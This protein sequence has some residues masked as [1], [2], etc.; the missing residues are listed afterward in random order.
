MISR[1][2]CLFSILAFLWFGCKQEKIIPI[3]TV[4]ALDDRLTQLYQQSDFPGFSVAVVSQDQ[5]VYQKGFGY[6]DLAQKTPFTTQ[7]IQ[8]IGSVSKTFIAAALMKAVEEGHFTLET[9]INDIL[10]F[11]VVN[12]YFPDSPIQVKHLVTHTSGITDREAAY[13][14]TYVFEEIP[15]VTLK[16]FLF[17]YF[18][19]KGRLYSQDNFINRAP[20]TTYRYTNLG[21]ALAAY[22]IEVK[23]GMSFAEYCEKAI[24][25]PLQ[26]TDSHWFYNSTLVPAYATLYKVNREAYPPYSL[27]TYP[28]GGL[29]TSCQDLSRYMVEMLKGCAGK[30]SLLTPQSF[31]TMFTAQFDSSNMPQQMDQSEPNRAVFWA[32]NRSGRLV[33]SG[34]DPGLSV[35]VSFDPKNKTGR[36]A[37]FNTELEESKKLVEQFAQIS[38]ALKNFESNL[39][40]Q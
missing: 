10:P 24:L 13:E 3:T 20:G 7:T 32:F 37:L 4:Q 19:S 36:I 30:S 12:P 25:K 1:S 40:I 11:P 34:G 9:V 18:A 27:I 14:Q 26:L 23:T 2:Y 8:P 35:F 17:D 5:V 33:H 15:S 31:K 21:A 6:A 39:P 29:R 16:E 22:L 38:E 28:D